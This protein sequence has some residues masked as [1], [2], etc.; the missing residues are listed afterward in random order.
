MYIQFDGISI[1]ADPVFRDFCGPEMASYGSVFTKLAYWRYRK[2]ACQV[3]DLPTLD[4]VVIS[5]DHYDHLDI[6]SVRMIAKHFPAVKWFVPG[7]SKDLFVSNN[8]ADADV[9]E[10]EWW[11][12]IELPVN[13]RK[14]KFICTPTQHWCQRSAVDKNKVCL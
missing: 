7:G 1:L 8:C 6:G 5:H 3:T 4:A 10:M 11:Q 2:A 14:F 12:E 9:T 13:G